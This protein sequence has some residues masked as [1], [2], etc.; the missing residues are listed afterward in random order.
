[1]QAT[2]TI[3]TQTRKQAMDWSLVLASQGIEPMI[4]KGESG[5][6]LIVP[7]ENYDVAVDAIR[8]YRA[9]NRSWPWR[10]VVLREGL[11][12]DWASLAW[13]GLIVVFHWVNSRIDLISR[14]LM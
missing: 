12:F 8:K 9:E 14:G 11:I 6:V 5:Y 1:M 4:E 10:Q 3:P 13:V 7:A 2:M